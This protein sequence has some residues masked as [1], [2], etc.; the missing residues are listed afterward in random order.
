MEGSRNR[1]RRP[2]NSAMQ[3][4]R[5]RR[6]ATIHPKV[7][8]E[9]PARR[10]GHPICAASPATSASK[11]A[12]Q[13]G[14]ARRSSCITTQTGSATAK[15]SGSTRTSP[16]A[17][18]DLADADA[19]AGAERR[20]LREVA[21]GAEGE[22]LAREAG[23]PGQRRPQRRRLAVVA[24]Q[25]EA[26]KLVERRRRAAPCRGSRA[27]RT[28]RARPRRPGARPAPP[29]PGRSCAPRRRRRG[30]AGPAP[31]STRRARASA[32]G[33]ARAARR[34][35]A[36]AARRRRPRSRSP[37]P[38]PRRPRAR[39]PPRGA[40][41]PR[42]RPSPRRRA[43]PR[44]P[45]RSAT[46]RARCAGTAAARAPPRAGRRGAPRSAGSAPS[47]RRRARQRALREDRRKRPIVVPARLAAH[48]FLYS[49][50]THSGNSE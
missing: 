25:V 4:Y 28:G 40:A 42:P 10:T 19:E 3:F 45:P 16:R 5:G 35:S 12:R 7:A 2:H 34:G 18:A 27:S 17:E 14:L 6:S 46:A 9:R 23:Y 32:A 15:A 31:R 38:C 33:A 29:A 1:L 22:A 50:S 49:Y 43:R 48:G 37:A 26:P 39:P 36:A 20:H 13:R 8:A 44:A 47:A 41:P 11:T 21:V 30:A 24:D